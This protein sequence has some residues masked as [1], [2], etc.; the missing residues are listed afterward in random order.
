MKHAT[1]DQD[2]GFV[3]VGIAKKATN[4]MADHPVHGRSD[5]IAIP[6]GTDDPPPIT[7]RLRGFGGLVGKVTSQ[8]KPVA[9]ATIT[10][11]PKG[12]GAQVQIAQSEDD[13]SFTL[14]KVP[15]GTVVVSAMQQNMMGMSLK[16]TSTTVQVTARKQTKV[17][18]D[19]PVG[20]VALA[21][22][23]K[24]LPG[25]KVDSAQVF[26]FRG[27]VAMKNAKELTDAFMGGGVAGMKFWF[28]DGKPVPEFEELVAGDYSVCTIPIAGDLNDTTFQQRLQEHMTSL[29]V[30]CKQTKVTPSPT[31]QTVVHEVPTMSPLPQN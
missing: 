6:E 17:T 1:T 23:V 10:A 8:G 19:I 7:L 25:H 14:A 20:S 15:E 29:A 4:I 9:G 22:Q 3:L 26:L 28:G 18:I 21:V 27:I 2:G 12:G 13:G 24:P 5:A 16:S 31:K 30:Y 11:T